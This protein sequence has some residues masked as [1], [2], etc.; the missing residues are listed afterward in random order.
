[1]NGKVKVI[2]VFALCVASAVTGAVVSQ[3]V[4]RAEAQSVSSATVATM[5][6]T[7]PAQGT[8]GSG[9]AYTVVPI[10]DSGAGYSWM[11]Y[12]LAV[13]P[14]GKVSIIATHPKKTDELGTIVKQFSIK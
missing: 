5:G 6:S 10:M 2:L 1:M 7:I 14:D 12:A 8:Y 9:G 4:P 13:G 3:L 11:A